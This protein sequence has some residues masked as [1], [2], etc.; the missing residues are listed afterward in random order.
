MQTCQRILHVHP[1]RRQIGGSSGGRDRR[2]ARAALDACGVQ[3]RVKRP[4]VKGEHERV[5]SPRTVANGI[6]TLE[7]L[8]YTG[9]AVEDI[10]PDAFVTRRRFGPLEEKL[11]EVGG[12]LVPMRGD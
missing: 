10:R 11:G 5:L 7:Q 12:V 6:C 3:L 8:V 2:V 9:L 1:Q 4:S